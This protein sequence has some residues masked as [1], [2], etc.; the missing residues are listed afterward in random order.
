MSS[1]CSPLSLQLEL[2][3]VSQLRSDSPQWLSTPVSSPLHLEV[4]NLNLPSA[5]LIA[6]Q[7][8]DYGYQVPTVRWGQTLG[9]EKGRNRS[10]IPLRLPTALTSP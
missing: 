6:F 3:S 1:L 9:R 5:D 2:S 4:E 10:H 8:I 7:A